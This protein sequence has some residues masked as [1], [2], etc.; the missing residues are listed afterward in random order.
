MGDYTPT[1]HAAGLAA[2]LD[3]YPDAARMSRAD[4]VAEA[5]F[6]HWWWNEG[7]HQEASGPLID[8]LDAAVAKRDADPGTDW[9]SDA[10][11]RLMAALTDVL[12]D[13]CRRN[14]AEANGLCRECADVLR[15]EQ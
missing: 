12:C 7:R 5:D 13:L 11:D 9:G 15:A 14:E 3:A 4:L 8:A 6:W 1:E 10:H 2:G